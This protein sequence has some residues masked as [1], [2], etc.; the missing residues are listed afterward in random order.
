MHSGVD[1]LDWMS[2]GNDL[3]VGAQRWR[4]RSERRKKFF[5]F[6]P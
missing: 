2:A 6:M 1:E 3:P 4:C 5:P